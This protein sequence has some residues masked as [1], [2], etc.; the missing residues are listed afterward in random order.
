MTKTQVIRCAQ[1][2]VKIKAPTSVRHFHCPKCKASNVVAGLADSPQRLNSANGKPVAPVS[3]APSVPV[4]FYGYLTQHFAATHGLWVWWAMLAILVGM[5]VLSLFKPILQVK[6]MLAV[7][8]GFGVFS[9]GIG[10]FYLV[11]Q[12][13]AYYFGRIRI[14]SPHAR[15]VLALLTYGSFVMMF[16]MLVVPAVEYFTP[17][18]GLL[19]TILP[20]ARTV[21]AR[22]RSDDVAQHI[23]EVLDNTTSTSP[24]AVKHTRASGSPPSNVDR[25]AE[26][27][28][29]DEAPPN[30]KAT[31]EKT[32]KTDD[33]V[34]PISVPDSVPTSEAP[35]PATE[36]RTPS[37]VVPTTGTQL[38]VAEGVGGTSEEATKDAFR[39]AVRQV[40]GAV[41][42]ADTLVKNDELI[43][44]QV[45][46]YSDG[47]ITKYED[48]PGSRKQQGGLYRVKIN[49]TVERRS[50]I[51]KLKAANVTVREI[52]GKSLFAEVITQ[53]DAES[54]LTQILRK[55]FEGFPQ[56]LLTAT[57]I[58]KP[59]LVSK[60]ED[61]ATVR[62]T[63]K[64]E[65]NLAAYKVFAE[66]LNEKLQ[67]MALEIGG[68]FSVP[69]K[70]HVRNE[71][72][73]DVAKSDKNAFVFFR[74]NV[75]GFDSELFEKLVPRSFEGKDKDRLNDK[76]VTLILTTHMSK[77]A[78]HFECHY[79]LL[80]KAVQSLLF[81]VANRKGTGKLSLLAGDGSLVMTDRFSLNQSFPWETYEEGFIGTLMA[82][83]GGYYGNTNSPQLF[84]RDQLKDQK[85]N[86]V[87]FWINPTFLEPDE[88]CHR[89]SLSIS[90]T[91]S[92]SLEEIQSISD[93]RCEI[94][95]AE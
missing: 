3:V 44:D 29:L 59:E 30:T 73:E 92:L 17:A 91:L 60:A 45:L 51:A 25:Q 82:A 18:E 26:D 66:R 35:S 10:I 23:P 14:V 72:Q 62:F 7:A 46:T 79:Y 67:K 63:V 15:N 94:S 39:N 21:Q 58:G 2:G 9:C 28:V 11:Q 89:P 65:P 69:F 4:S 49:A 87:L 90:R 80:D 75:G 40:V 83:G 86:A 5:P 31:D 93:A 20:D 76:Q 54:G 56:A 41:V 81:D 78:D 22:L 52:D 37:A 61:K 64:L 16:P 95:F 71:R 33:A 27:A 42:D 70:E 53:L 32:A 24:T 6:G 34:E 8:L 57:V 84:R 36:S 68:D 13:V 55:E 19:V 43:D 50:V 48:V 85:K 74:E 88:V 12:V 38:I 77:S 1:C 47:F